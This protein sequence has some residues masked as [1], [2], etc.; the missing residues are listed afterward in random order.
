MT[1]VFTYMEYQKKVPSYWLRASFAAILT[2][3]GVG[4]WM[5]NLYLSF[6]LG[7]LPF[8]LKI[9]QI[10]ENQKKTKGQS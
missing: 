5:E 1:Q 9:K 10:F 6:L 4:Q 2:I 7:T 3:W 8:K